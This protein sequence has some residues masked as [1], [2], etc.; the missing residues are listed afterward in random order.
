[1]DTAV[2]EIL[3]NPENTG[4]PAIMYHNIGKLQTHASTVLNKN[5]SKLHTFIKLQYQMSY[6]VSTLTIHGSYPL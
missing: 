1:M 2:P 3:E 5:P 4:R 6:T